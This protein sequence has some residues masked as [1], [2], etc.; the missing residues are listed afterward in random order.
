VPNQKDY[1]I[2]VGQLKKLSLKNRSSP[3]LSPVIPDLGSDR[4]NHT[5]GR[6]SSAGPPN[7]VIAL[8]RWCK[9]FKRMK[10]KLV[11]LQWSGILVVLRR[12]TD[13]ILRKIRCIRPPSAAS[14][15]AKLA[16][17]APVLLSSP[18]SRSLN[19]PDS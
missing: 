11:V 1:Q 4:Q 15:P 14:R 3:D 6:A 16:Q 2:T 19:Y 8:P 5:S 12:H 17:L 13:R 10:I 9:N 18:P 7:R